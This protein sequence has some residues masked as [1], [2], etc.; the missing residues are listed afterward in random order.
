MK[1]VLIA[2]AVLTAAATAHGTLLV[3]DQFSYS[4]GGLT[5]VSAGAWTR[6]SGSGNDLQVVDGNLSYPG[7][8]AT[9]RMLQFGG[10]DYDDTRTFSSQGGAV[11]ASL[12]LRVDRRGTSGST[13]FLAFD[14]G[15]G[16]DGRVFVQ[17][18]SVAG[19][20]QFGINTGAGASPGVTTGNYS[21]NLVLQLVSRFDNSTDV[22]SLW[23]NPGVSEIA[24]DLIFTNVV[25]G[26]TL[27]G[28]TL[29]QG[30]NWDNGDSEVYVDAI[31]VG[32]TW[33][34]VQPIPE[35]ATP[36]LLALG[37]VAVCARRCLRE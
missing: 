6:T 36:V 24:P 12:L 21:T 5:G 7:Y 37:V 31:R 14:E 13:Y 30:D 32:T 18:G 20:V 17:P 15:A 26:T 11:Y 33:G 22:I 3:E 23:V 29:R 4:S 34:D 1:K 10:G 9:G 8:S 27:D 2:L 28:L 19:T 16:F 25:A 35:P